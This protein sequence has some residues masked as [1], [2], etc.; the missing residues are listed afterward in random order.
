MIFPNAAIIIVNYNQI[1]HTLECINSLL[2]ADADLSQIIVVD[3]DSKDN[4]VEI[5]R[6]IFGT[7]LT[8]LALGDNKGYPH[9]LNKGIPDA[10]SRDFEWLILMNND[11]VV[12]KLFLKELE[13]ATKENPQGELI[14]PAILYYD[15]PE[16]IWNIG[17]INLPGTLIGYRS[18]RGRKYSTTIPDYLAID[19][20][21]GCTMMVKRTV[22][23]KIGLFDDLT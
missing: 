23:D 14:A 2:N 12:D 11:V 5:L 7:S 1:E 6:K 3:N 19:V 15:H 22:I 16:I 20:L 4:S 13:R 17:Y 18:Y 8:I 10:M 21:H 9:A